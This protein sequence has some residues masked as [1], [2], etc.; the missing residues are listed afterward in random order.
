MRAAQEGAA[1]GAGL[2][3]RELQFGVEGT[4]TRS[5]LKGLAAVFAGVLHGISIAVSP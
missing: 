3:G 1:V 5:A 4:V 2:R